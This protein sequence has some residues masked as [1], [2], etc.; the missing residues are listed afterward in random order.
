[1]PGLQIFLYE[2][3]QYN[4]NELSH[5]DKVEKL[6]ADCIQIKANGGALHVN[7]ILFCNFIGAEITVFDSLLRYK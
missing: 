7:N 4:N 2:N 6:F 1:M 5:V 3:V